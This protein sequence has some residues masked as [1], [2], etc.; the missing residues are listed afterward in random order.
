MQLAPQDHDGFFKVWM[1]DKPTLRNLL[2]R[3][4]PEAVRRTVDLTIDPEVL[5]VNYDRNTPMQ[6]LIY[7]G[8]ELR[9]TFTQQGEKGPLPAIFCMV[10]YHGPEPWSM[11]PFFHTMYGDIPAELRS[12]VLDFPYQL[13][14]LQQIPNQEILLMPLRTSSGLMALKYVFSPES[15]QREM[16]L[17]MLDQIAATD[18]I[19]ASY[20]LQL[21]R[22]WMEKY[23]VFDSQMAD[24]V[25]A[26]LH[27]SA[28]VETMLSNF[29][30]TYLDKG[31]QEGIQEGEKKGRQEGQI[32][33]L[34]RQMQRRFCYR[35]CPS[36]Q[37]I[38]YARGDAPGYG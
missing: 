10:V 31:R 11:P 9:A 4:L 8:E 18:E 35:R 26:K 7:Q 32:D 14:N 17:L 13:L 34:L 33:L 16:I 30:Q 38:L 12:Y 1:D 21:V 2:Q 27:H 19:S 5:K 36:F 25:A 28:E 37:P 20:L 6:F 15:Q 3:W 23:S 29:A 24:R 22:Y